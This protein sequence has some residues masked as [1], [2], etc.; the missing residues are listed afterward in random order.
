MDGCG[1][2]SSGGVG[3]SG[4]KTVGAAASER[5]V[6][7]PAEEERNSKRNSEK[8]EILEIE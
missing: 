1:V 3:G 6:S 4:G 8:L 7:F 5:G 2:M